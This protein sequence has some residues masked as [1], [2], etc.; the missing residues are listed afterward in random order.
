MKKKGKKQQ[1]KPEIEFKDKLDSATTSAFNQYHSE[2]TSLENLASDFKWTRNDT[3]YI[4]YKAN[5]GRQAKT[6]KKV[7][8]VNNK[9]LSSVEKKDIIQSIVRRA[10]QTIRINSASA[11]AG[12]NNLTINAIS[13]FLKHGL[14]TRNC[15]NFLKYHGCLC[16]E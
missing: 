4:E 15:S 9:N 11:C 3:N 12:P 1:M 16:L 7:N 6:R 13:N 8:E 10:K 2:N 14:W 5:I